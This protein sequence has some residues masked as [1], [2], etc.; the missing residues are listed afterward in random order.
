[1]LLTK[2]VVSVEQLGLGYFFTKM[3]KKLTVELLHAVMLQHCSKFI[4]KNIKRMTIINIKDLIVFRP[5][6]ICVENCSGGY[7]HICYKNAEN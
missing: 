6:L 3:D 1:M 2:D 5:F 4:V 7:F